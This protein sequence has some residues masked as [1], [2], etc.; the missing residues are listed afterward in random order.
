MADYNLYANNSWI[1]QMRNNWNDD[2]TLSQWQQQ[3]GQDKHSRQMTVDYKRFGTS[4]KLLTREGLDVAGPLPD[5]VKRIW[6]PPNPKRV[7]SSWTQ[8]PAGCAK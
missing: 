8:W 6:Q 7:G 2:N 4:F 3:F 5:E 1:P